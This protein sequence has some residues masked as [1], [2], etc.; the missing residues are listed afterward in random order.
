ML[1]HAA[2]VHQ[3]HVNAAVGLPLNGNMHKFHIAIVLLALGG[4]ACAE[5]F[6]Q[7][8]AMA[9][10]RSL[11]R[12]GMPAGKPV[13]PRQLSA[14]ERAELRRQ[15]AREAQGNKRSRKAP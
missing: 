2:S 9:D 6:A 8:P 14:E 3:A 7:P 1:P 12:D 5:G 4:S 13:A 10:L 15:L 11:L